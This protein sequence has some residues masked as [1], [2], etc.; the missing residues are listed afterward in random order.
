MTAR[1]KNTGP[2]AAKVPVAV[3]AAALRVEPSWRPTD[4][5]IDAFLKHQRSQMM[6]TF[7]E[8][9]KKHTDL[10]VERAVDAADGRLDGDIEKEP[11]NDV[12]A[13]LHQFK[14]GDK[15]SA[16]LGTA[17]MLAGKSVR[18]DGGAEDWAELT[19]LLGLDGLAAAKS[20][21]AI[22]QPFLV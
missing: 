17:V 9:D 12:Q 4:E 19:L 13:V 8:Q 10:E 18:P 3:V 1:L 7:E 11:H 6:T 21:A 2:T 20:I 5:Q 22:L 14:D 15:V 16:L